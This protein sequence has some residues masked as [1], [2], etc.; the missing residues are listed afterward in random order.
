[1]SETNLLKGKLLKNQPEEFCNCFLENDVKLAVEWLK[2]ELKE[3]SKSDIS[4]CDTEYPIDIDDA[5][6]KVDIAF[7]DVVKSLKE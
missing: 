7:E 2:A 4:G 1:M 5:L 3:L 6:E